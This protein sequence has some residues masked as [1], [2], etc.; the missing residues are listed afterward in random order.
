MGIR[1]QLPLQHKA[2]TKQSYRFL[3]NSLG[4]LVQLAELLIHG[5]LIQ[6]LL[7]HLH[8]E[9]LRYERQRGIL[10]CLVHV[11]IDYQA[12]HGVSRGPDLPDLPVQH[13]QCPHVVHFL[14]L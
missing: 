2:G 8:G 11:R 10:R 13:Q 14:Q 12:R 5:S 7:H 6:L 9:G 3:T 4:D 1:Y